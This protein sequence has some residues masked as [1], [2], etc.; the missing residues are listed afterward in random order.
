MGCGEVGF[1]FI[2]LFVLAF[3]FLFLFG[4]PHTAYEGVINGKAM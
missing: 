2:P 4:K 3:L 1:I